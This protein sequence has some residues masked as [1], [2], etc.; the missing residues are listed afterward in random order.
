MAQKT[1]IKVK[2]SETGLRLQIEK[3]LFT[4]PET[5]EY[6]GLSP[7][8][9]YRRCAPGSSDPFPVKPVRIGGHSLRFR[10]RDL[11][12]YIDSL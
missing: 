8:T 7:K 1:S 3:I 4:L 12:Q 5:A 9:L 2:K 11:D 6:L 10:K